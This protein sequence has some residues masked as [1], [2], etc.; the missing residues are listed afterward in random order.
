MK[1][2]NLLFLFSLFL[3]QFSGLAAWADGYPV[4]SISQD[5]QQNANAVIRH[6]ETVYTVESPT[7]A[8]KYVKKVVT[9]LNEEGDNHAALHLSYD[10]FSSVKK[11]TG[12][13]YNAAGRTI[14]R[15]KNRDIS[16]V[17]YSDYGD[18]FNDARE[19]IATPSSSTYPY[20][21]EYEYE[22]RYK[23]S[24][25]YPA[26]FPQPAADVA[27]ENASFKILIPENQG[28][29]YKEYNLPATVQEASADGFNYYYWEVKN[30]KAI[31]EEPHSYPL[32]FV[33]YLRTA[34]NEFEIAGYEGNMNTWKQFG[35]WIAVL[36]AGRRELNEESRQKLNELVADTNT[37]RERVE[38]IYN[39]LQ[40]NTR[41]VNIAL[42]IGGWQPFEANFV[43]E[44]GYGDCKALSNYTQTMLEAVGIDSYYTLVYAGDNTH[45]VDK[46]FPS[47]QFNHVILCVPLQTDT[48]WLECTSQNAPCGYLG[49]F[50]DNRDVLLITPE[51]GK[52]AHTPAYRQNV[53]IENRTA[54]VELAGD[55]SAS[56]R[57]NTSY[58]GLNYDYYDF[59]HWLNLSDDE[60]KNWLYERLEIT[61]SFE[62]TDFSFREIREEIPVVE[63]AIALK[64]RNLTSQS[65]KRLF[66]T[67]NLMNRQTYVP[68]K[69][70]NRRHAIRTDFDYTDSD[71]ITYQLPEG[72]TV[73][74]LPENEMIETPFGSYSATFT[75]DG[76]RVIYTRKLKR[77]AGPFPANDYEAYIAFFE[78]I[79]KGDEAKVVLIQEE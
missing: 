39:Y 31:E 18:L 28:F 74:Y 55:G 6:Y 70:R 38:I 12:A 11:I 8:V 47:S 76:N 66:L 77:N 67:A 7:N 78:A 10:S 22:I 73:E 79:R 16:D 64:I 19:K 48:I 20:T 63:E 15:L 61:S 72:F 1:K 23:A 69:D 50:T 49:T 33:P 30:I 44:K 13:I 54:S 43:D 71:S 3:M 5:L 51:G 26:W 41:Y 59:W 40:N 34:P 75:H 4:Y 29:R 17:S 58:K 25:F 57:V 53:N 32:E 52:I 62:I 14:E 42:G 46:E 27:V 68:D 35:E 56:V 24:L 37:D 21:V 9:V 45:K 60:Q 65:G 2:N 36:N